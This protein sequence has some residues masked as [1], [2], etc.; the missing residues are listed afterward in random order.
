[1][2]INQAKL[3][4]ILIWTGVS[5]WGV[6]G[7][8]LPLRRRPSLS[9]FLPIHLVFVLSGVQVRKLDGDD[10][11]RLSSPKIKTASNILMILGIAAWLP[12]FM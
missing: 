4:T 7:F 9:L 11:M 10:G 8:L 6:Y 1:M 5:V 12:Y 3:G 2:K